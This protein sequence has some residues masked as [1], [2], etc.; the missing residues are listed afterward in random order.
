MMSARRSSVE[1]MA[2]G[3]DALLPSYRCHVYSQWV[4]DLRLQW[5]LAEWSRDRSPVSNRGY[6]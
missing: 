2:A 3:A 1:P 6:N 5:Q 4:Q